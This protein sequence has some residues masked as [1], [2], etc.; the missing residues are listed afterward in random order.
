MAK[1]STFPAD[2]VP[3]RTG[4]VLAVLRQHDPVPVPATALYLSIEDKRALA[5][6]F[7]RLVGTGDIETVRLVPGDAHFQAAMR[8]TGL[9][10]E[11]RAAPV[12]AYRL[13]G[14]GRDAGA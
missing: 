7:Q 14:Q 13:T 9:G 2:D 10:D 6:V 8:L 12:T 5:D 1:G 3:D 4:L 11:A